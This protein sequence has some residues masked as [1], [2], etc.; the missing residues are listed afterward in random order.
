MESAFISSWI[1][2]CFIATAGAQ[3]DSK[4]SPLSLLNTP[5][6]AALWHIR[7]WLL[8]TV[9]EKSVWQMVL[10]SSLS[11]LA[12]WYAWRKHGHSSHSA[13]SNTR[14]TNGR[15]AQKD[16]DS[17]DPALLKR[18]STF[19]TYKTSTYTYP[20]IRVFFRAHP[21]FEK[22]PST[23]APLPL[24]VFIHG[25]GGSVA[26][27]NPLLN[28]L[29]NLASCLAIDLPGCGLSAFKT[30]D[31]N[32]YKMENLVELLA[33]VIE[34]HRAENQGV[35]LIGHSLG[36][37]LAA[38]LASTTSPCSNGISKNVVGLVGIC[39]RAAPPSEEEVSM[40]KKLLLI[41]S[42]IFS[43]WRAWDRRGGLESASVYRFVGQDADK[44]TKA[45]Q[46]RF[47]EQSK[48]PVWRRMASGTLPIYKNGIPVGGLPGKEVWAGLEVPV[49]LV[50]GEADHVTKP[51]E[52][53]KIASFLGKSHPVQNSSSEE[54]EPIVDA[55]AP[56]DTS[57]EES[58]P[59]IDKESI[60][61]ITA[62]DFL[63]PN[64]HTIEDAHEDPST[65]NESLAV[66]PPQPLKPRK[67]LKTTVLPDPASH[68]LLYQPATARVLAGL[69]S[70]FLCRQISPRLDLGWQLSYLSTSGKWDV[71][72]LAKWQAVRPVSEPIANVFRAMKT[73]REVDDT[74]SPAAFSQEWKGIV[75]DVMDISHDLPVYDP[76]SLEA[77]GIRYHK[78]PT[79]SKIPPTDDEVRNFVKFVDGL[80]EEQ[81]ARVQEEG[82][83]KNNVFIGVHCHYGFNR[84]GYFLVCYLVER[85]GFSLE[86]AISEFATKR[87]KG[88]KHAHFLDKL[89]LK[90]AIGLKR[91][92]T[93]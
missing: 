25:L 43:L 29:V 84:T 59:S 19:K 5:N 56:V 89:Y 47:N 28:S 88:I 8:H 62:E 14:E 42:P 49:F 7:Q 21:Q 20:S 51:V 63:E 23:P 6:R 18:N 57:I 87:P 34:E 69:T 17:I 27:F 92:P 60:E 1:F 4:S 15:G 68:A 32:A 46:Y 2:V 78:F 12:L 53:E 86:A 52:L 11:V 48:T 10:C 33:H 80:K 45:L 81:K 50:A 35:V 83:D 38:L 31:W 40:F 75:T 79:V 30:K 82:L 9:Q 22:L 74:H 64:P 54:S 26:Q 24:L 37:S 3:S 90:Y 44:T 85:C 13:G 58:K 91:A 16:T 61:S 39:P 72:N 70:D 65:P 71:K 73:L 76:K 66:V 55:A 36:C 77:R 67:V 41:P 93:L